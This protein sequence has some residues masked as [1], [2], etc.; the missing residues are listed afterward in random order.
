MAIDVKSIIADALL[1]LCERKS[2]SKITI[3]DIQQ[4]SGVSRQTFY[5]HFKDKPDLIQYIYESRVISHWKSPSNTSLNYYEATLDALKSDAEYHTFLKQACKMTGA[6]C[7]VDYMY[8]YSKDFDCAWHQALYGKE[9]MPDELKFASEYHSAAG[10]H[11][12][13]QWILNDMPESPE[14]LLD[15]F[16][17]LRLYSLNDLILEDL[18]E[19]SPYTAAAMTAAT[20]AATHSVWK[21][22]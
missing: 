16:I 9:P 22:R 12:R 17:L 18:G 1:N 13:I 21:K 19:G 14:E 10:M 2:L 8:Q 15:R 20:R 4:E 6:N 11:M 3:A 5:N 7:L